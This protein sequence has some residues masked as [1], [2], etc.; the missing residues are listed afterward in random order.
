MISLKNA[1]PLLALTAAISAPACAESIWSDPLRTANDLSGTPAAAL[2]GSCGFDAQLPAPLTLLDAVERALCRNPQTRQAWANVKVQ[3]AA[4]GVSRAAYLP[5]LT[6]AGSWSKADNRYSYP[7]FPENNSSLKTHSSNANLSLNWVL[8]DSGLRAANLENARQLL[9]AASATQDD[10]LQ[11][12][13]LN[14]VQSFY[15]AQAAQAMLNATVDAELAAQQSFR[16]SEARYQAGAGTLADKLQAQTSYAQASLKRAQEAGDLQSGLGALAIVM[17][18]RPNTPLALAD[19]GLQAA[20]APLLQQAADDLIA[21]AVRSH[22]KI[23][24][25]QA[26]LKSAQAQVDAA[27]AEGRPTLSLFATGDRNDT[28]IN[29]V[30]SKQ[31]ITSRSIG[32]QVS[33]P[34]FDGFGRKYKVRGAQAQAESRQADLENIEQQVML[35][36][37][38][39]DQAL[40]T[41]AENLNT[42]DILLRSAKQSFD[43]AQGRY[44]AGVGNILE[45][46]KAQ[47]DLASA[48]QQRILA[49]TSWQTARLRLAASLGRLR[50]D[51]I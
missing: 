3:A 24:A 2:T 17:G 23:L 12:V 47:S 39:S 26:Q 51:G 29:Q 44:R 28:P 11:T 6:A 38:K 49:L 18:L 21:D 34:L 45:L 7:D 22:P 10:V 33:I 32:L 41:E 1:L 46:L 43:V 16:A 15:Q 48:Q 4:L 30:S 14:T 35:E 42:T 36:V 37:W 20:D 13:F 31:T 19:L 5:T 8:Y 9:N 40:R 25:A 50:L 27:R